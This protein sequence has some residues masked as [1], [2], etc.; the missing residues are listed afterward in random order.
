M[1]ESGGMLQ[2]VRF[3]AFPVLCAGVDEQVAVALNLVAGG[4]SVDV[5]PI[6]TASDYVNV[7]DPGGERAFPSLLPI[8][9]G[10]AASN[11]Q[12]QGYD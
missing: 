12:G 8:R 5:V 1:I 2:F 11:E 4:P 3:G 10:S 7:D 9:R 6:T